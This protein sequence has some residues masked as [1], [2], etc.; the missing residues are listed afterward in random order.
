MTIAV[1]YKY[2]F[3]PVQENS[4]DSV[5]AS[6]PIVWSIATKEFIHLVRQ[7]AR[8]WPNL[9]VVWIQIPNSGKL[10]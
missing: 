7:I 6:K 5:L 3:I 9:N 10:F 2:P 4:E 8:C 1:I